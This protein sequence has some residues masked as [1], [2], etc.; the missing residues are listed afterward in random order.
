MTINVKSIQGTLSLL[1]FWLVNQYQVLLKL[2][3]Q[4]TH[5]LVSK[6]M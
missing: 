6:Q 4:L 5:A 2:H 3:V 1:E